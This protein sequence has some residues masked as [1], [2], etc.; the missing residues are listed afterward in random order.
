MKESTRNEPLLLANGNQTFES[1]E[2][3]E[4]R[5]TKK[6]RGSLHLKCN[7]REGCAD[8]LFLL[9]RNSQQAVGRHALVGHH[10]EESA[11]RQAGVV[12]KHL[13]VIAGGKP[14]TELP[15]VDGGYRQTQ[16]FGDFFQGNVI[17]LSPSTKRR[18]KTRANVAAEI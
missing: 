7:W 12:R 2:D 10:A 1:Y 6:Q 16:I 4:Q 17:L 13:E 3:Y 5:F 15:G 8:V 11:R 14:P 9:S 18:R